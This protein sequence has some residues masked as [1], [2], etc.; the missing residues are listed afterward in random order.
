MSRSSVVRAIA[1]AAVLLLIAALPA[2]A[3]SA[4][5]IKAAPRSTGAVALTFD[6]GWNH[7]A[8]SR[9]ADILR[10][11]NVRATFFVNGRELD[12]RPWKWRRILEG[13]PVGNHTYA[14]KRMTG[15]SDDAIR[16]QLK[17][18]ERVHEEL[19]GRPMLK[20]FRPPFGAYSE[21]VRRVAAEAGY[22]RM[23]LWNVQPHD[24]S[25]RTTAGQIVR[26]A[27]GARRGSI[28]LLHCRYG[29]TVQAL[30][31]IIRHYRQR[32]I[33]LVGLDE[34]LGR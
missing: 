23:V 30:P 17:R 8:C 29:A 10:A 28:I 18:N 27:T 31:K 15:L 9:I 32:G 4:Q 3:A 21:R 6:D 26:R 16:R 14:H 34:L 13:M 20:L 7:R 25:P 1:L 22:G 2:A 5:I 11:R 33:R 12:E 24:W 19:L